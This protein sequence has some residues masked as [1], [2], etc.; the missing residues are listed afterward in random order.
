MGKIDPKDLYTIHYY[1]YGEAYFGSC[2]GYAY[3]IAR[4][5]LRDVHFTP[6]EKRDPAVLK[7]TVWPGPYCFART[8][9]DKKSS[10]EF[11]FS[12]EG[13]AEGARWLNAQMDLALTEESS[14]PEKKGKSEGC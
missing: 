10:R 2:C 5:P 14:E 6:P 4:E 11:A 9:E 7:F 1:E 12:A 13:L 8:P 3:R